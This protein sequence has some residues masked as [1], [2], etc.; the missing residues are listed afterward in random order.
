MGKRIVLFIIAFVLIVLIFGWLWLQQII[1]NYDLDV[2]M[3]LPILF[4]SFVQKP[5]LF[6]K[7]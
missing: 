5:S 2:S 1:D 6:Y 7:L 4:D 3:A